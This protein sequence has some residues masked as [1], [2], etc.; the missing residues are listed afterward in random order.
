MLKQL[1]LKKTDAYYFEKKK[2]NVAKYILIL[3]PIC[4][5]KFQS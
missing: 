5:E 2:I 4:T 1:T 3:K